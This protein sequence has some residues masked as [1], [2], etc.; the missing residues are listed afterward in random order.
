MKRS[1][2]A[3]RR[4]ADRIG[5][6]IADEYDFSKASR[7]VTAKRYAEGSNVVVLDPDVAAV[8]PNAAAVNTALRMLAR[9]A[10]TASGARHARRSTRTR[11]R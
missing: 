7:G 3:R 2:P 10:E 5:D 9:L 4:P 1:R 11:K 8:F 6:D